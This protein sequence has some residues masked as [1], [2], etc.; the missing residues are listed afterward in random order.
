MINENKGLK[1][2]FPMPLPQSLLADKSL[3]GI[4]EKIVEQIFDQFET[5]IIES[6]STGIAPSLH[7]NDIQ[8]PSFMIISE[9]ES[10]SLT[11][12]QRG[13]DEYFNVIRVEDGPI[14]LP[15]SILI[16]LAEMTEELKTPNR[17]SEIDKE[18]LI[19]GFRTSLAILKEDH[20]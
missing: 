7:P 1:H 17:L 19:D 15:F 10:P 11:E 18:L 12:N 9:M 5:Q 16:A 20:I 3:R 4:S 8:L 2:R 13:Y 14:V 6:W